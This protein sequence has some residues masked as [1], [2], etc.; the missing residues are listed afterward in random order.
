[1]RDMFRSR[2]RAQHLT[3]LAVLFFWSVA[4]VNAVSAHAAGNTYLQRLERR[5]ESWR[6]ELPALH[7]SATQA[8]QRV[9]GGGNL[10]TTGP[11]PGFPV[12][13]QG[14]SGG[15]VLVKNYTPKVTLTAADTIIA[16]LDRPTTDTTLTDLLD[17]ART[18][19]AHVVLFSNQPALPAAPGDLRYFP[20]HYT[21]DKLPAPNSLDTGPV[22]NVIGTWLWMSEFVSACVAE[23]KMPCMYE[24]IGMPNGR[25]RDAPFRGKTFHVAT[26]VKP[27]AAR[28]LG[29]RYLD[30]LL[31]SLKKL[32]TD[33][34]AAFERAAT[35]LRQS[36]TDGGTVHTYHLGHM[37]PAALTGP[38]SPDW[39]T[40]SGVVL[41]PTPNTTPPVLAPS[42]EGVGAHDIVLVIGYQSFPWAMQEGMEK[43]GAS[44]IVTSSHL[45]LSEFTQNPRNV[46][47][48]PFWDA[49]DAVIT[50]PGYDVPI[51]PISGIIQNGIYWQLVELATAK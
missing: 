31:A 17:K 1:M 19:G 50:L 38:P 23:G 3:F 36:H 35:L 8:A 27:D 18:A 42:V 39:F 25:E 51:L 12:E 9:I 6:G 21:A 24:S 40:V 28:N 43:S 34:T 41:P 44:W 30:V 48:N 11:Q 4:A 26:E 2:R 46:Y 15:M 7:A 14:R 29:G 5:A 10:Y 37:F 47:I 45:P 13:F 33:D 20:A 16:G 49:P 22:S 32:T